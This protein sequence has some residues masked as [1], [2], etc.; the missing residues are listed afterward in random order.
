MSDVENRSKK[1]IEKT[2]DYF[3]SPRV[4][5]LILVPVIDIG[6]LVAAFKPNSLPFD[7]I[8]NY[9]SLLQYLITANQPLVRKIC[10]LV[11]ISHFF[12][13]LAAMKIARKNKMKPTTTLLWT[14]QTFIYGLFSL[15]ILLRYNKNVKRSKKL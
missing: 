8:G 14:V 6:L 4:P 1:V 12:E 3:R 7:Y 5:W 2:E 9:G 15:R 10:Y 11:I 13:A